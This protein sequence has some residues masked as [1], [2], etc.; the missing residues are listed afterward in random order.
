MLEGLY[1]LLIG[2][3]YKDYEED[4]L[5]SLFFTNIFSIL[6]FLIIL[7]YGIVNLYFGFFLPAF[8]EIASSFILLLVFIYTRKSGDP[9]S[10]NYVKIALIVGL[11]VY[12]FLTG[13]SQGTGFLWV[14][15]FPVAIFA[16]TSS[17]VAI[18]VTL[19][20]YSFLI[21]FQVL[22]LIGI[23]SLPY[24][25][26]D[27]NTFLFSIVVVTAV[28]Y[29][30]RV[31]LEKSNKTITEQRVELQR[32][33]QRYTS[34]LEKKS[35]LEKDFT[36]TI[37]KFKDQNSQLENTKVAM[38]NLLEDIN[39]E[40][41]RSQEQTDRLKQFEEA[42]ENANDHIVFT[43]TDGEI[44]YANKAVEETTGFEKEE[45]IGKTPRIWGGQMSKEFY[46]EF[47][48]TI[49]Y[50]KKIFKGEVIN[51]K[52][53]GELYTASIQSIPILGDSGEIKFFVGIERDITE[54]KEIE[55]LKSEFVSIASHQLRTPATGVKWF[56]EILLDDK[57]G[58]L[59]DQQREYMKEVYHSNERMLKLIN[60]L[61]NVS[62]IETGKKF[63]IEIKTVDAADIINQEIKNMKIIAEKKNIT[64]L[65]DESIPKKLEIDLDP[66]KFSQVIKNLIDNGIKYSPEKTKVTVGLREEEDNA[67]FWV[68]DEGIGIPVAQQDRIFEKFFRADNV[69]KADT[70]GTGLGLYIVKA[71]VEGHQGS[72]SFETE[73]G[74]GTTF[75]ISFPKEQHSKDKR[76]IRV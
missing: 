11:Y 62:R 5:I 74:K 9:T 28:V 33:N 48:R 52:K 14:Y 70:D 45:I 61:L 56:T 59:N 72:V 21:I 36:L 54:D 26:E 41:N 8:M 25:A 2:Q 37:K 47:W 51:R 65:K 76:T 32:L 19:F 3:K 63:T 73:E 42:V 31:N 34:E 24:T 44:I 53:N 35:I 29:L 71:I 30:L 18:A 60:D 17:S 1:R 75:F 43:S 57:A 49:K 12:V 67:V 20:F 23:Y 16:I 69:L 58:E 66:D 50:D 39:E 55:K 7:A 13:G 6:G 4:R 15:T 68:K 64:I 27:V 46:D 10:F 22:N 40:K 38:I